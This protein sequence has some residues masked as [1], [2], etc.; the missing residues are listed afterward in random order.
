MGLTLHKAFPQLKPGGYVAVEDIHGAHYVESFF[1][2]AA[3]S[4]TWWA[5]QNQVA[6]LH[7]YPF[8]L[9]VHKVG[10]TKG[11]EF[12]PAA[13]AVVVDSFGAMWAAIPQN[14]GKTVAVQN[15]QWGSFLSNPSLANIFREFVHLHDYDMHGIPAGCQHTPSPVCTAQITNSPA[16]NQVVGVHIFASMLVVEAAAAPPNIQAVRRGDVFISYQ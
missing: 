5:S 6:S 8:E 1:V 13:P 14:P 3:E 4:I 16:Q 7:V 15:P 2:P 9:F 11:N 12:L 10:G